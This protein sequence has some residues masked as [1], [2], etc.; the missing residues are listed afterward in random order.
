MQ[1]SPDRKTLLYGSLG[2]LWLLAVI[3]GYFSTHKPFSPNELISLLTALWRIVIVFGL[4]SL[5]GGMGTRMLGGHADQ[6]LSQTIVQAALGLGILGTA[7]LILGSTLGLTLWIYA[8]LLILGGFLL[9]KSILFWWQSWRSLAP[10]WTR[11]GPLEKILAFFIF[12]ILG[13]ALIVSLA[14]PLAWDA[15]TYHIA[16][17][18]AF[19]LAGRVTYLPDNAFWGMSAL[20]E[21]LHTL[22]MLFGGDESA[23][24]LGWAISSLAIFGVF[25]FV[26]E[27]IGLRA[28]WAAAA[29]LLAG[30]TFSAS[31]AWGYVEWP[32]MLFGIVML[33]TLHEWLMEKSHKHIFLAGI[34]AGLALSTKY[35][36]GILLVAGVFVIL[37]EIKSL[38]WRG[39]GIAILLFGFSAALVM[40]PWLGKNFLATGNPFYP[41]F[42]PSG[43]MDQLR[44]DFLQKNALPRT[45]GES[46][47][48]PWLA[49]V[50]G[51]EGK[52]GFSASIGPL[53][54]GLSPL[55][56]LGGWRHRTAEQRSALKLA[57]IVTFV[58]L[59][60][61]AGASHA[62]GLL[63]QSRL[64]FAMFPAWAI[65][66]G[67]GF[68]SFETLSVQNIRFGR[69]AA[70]LVVLVLGF[71]IFETGASALNASALKMVLGQISP[72]EYRS[73][74]LGWY[75]SAMEGI[76]QLPP[77]SRVLLLWEPRNLNCLPKCDPDDLIDQWLHDMRTYGKADRILAVW[78]TQGYTHLLLNRGGASF[79][80]ENETW[81]TAADWHEL[82]A[83]LAQLPPPENFGTSYSLYSLTNP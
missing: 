79:A 45:W 51:V 35:T 77:E 68:A 13:N 33:T 67:I 62:A 25:G 23:A 56:F 75:A 16:V 31:P 71:S 5:A 24:L 53:L 12:P 9:R 1:T 20:V 19:L 66:A 27:Q 28:A 83:L 46:I 29:C 14:P 42:F 58:G 17:P 64:Y 38:R 57:A 44:I 69:L 74:N 60:M 4:V 41:S 30:G 73:Q 80:R 10:A 21:M 63:I 49:T 55:A 7:T 34:L 81:Y 65:L 61:W 39:A 48:L 43:A 70:V 3:I 52:V 6:A 37:S 72:Q 18:R 11:S 59:A 50:W 40:L 36:S 82:E 8:L 78:K 47:L 2:L 15:L 76:R 32:S 22:A 54:L 26:N